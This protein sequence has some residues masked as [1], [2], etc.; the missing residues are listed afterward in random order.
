MVILCLGGH[1]SISRCVVATAATTNWLNCSIPI[2]PLSSVHVPID[3]PIFSISK[4]II[5]SLWCW[6]I[7]QA[8]CHCSHATPREPGNRSVRTI[9]RIDLK[10]SGGRR[11]LMH[12]NNNFTSTKIVVAEERKHCMKMRMN[13][14]RKRE[15]IEAL[16]VLGALLCGCQ[17]VTTYKQPSRHSQHVVCSESDRCAD[18][19]FYTYTRAHAIRY[20]PQWT[21]HHSSV[22]STCSATDTFPTTTTSIQRTFIT[23]CWVLTA[24]AVSRFLRRIET[25]CLRIYCSF[26]C[27]KSNVRRS[28]LSEID[29]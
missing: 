8:N 7:A 24:W 2:C 3:W 28:V 23:V 17:A 22:W 13:R 9:L 25:H 16:H 15:Q 4:C 5:V 14:T 29:T 27:I 11:A 1:K 21:G 26:P 20:T 19:R 10:S 12:N 18:V 6:F